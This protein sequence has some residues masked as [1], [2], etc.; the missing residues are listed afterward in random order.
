MTYLKITAP[1][2]TVTFVSENTDIVLNLT[3]YTKTEGILRAGRI[4]GVAY[5]TVTPITNIPAYDGTNTL[6]E[7]GRLSDHGQIQTIF[8]NK[9]TPF[10]S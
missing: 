1:D 7:Y 3:P 10:F 4:T 6:Y 9:D 5:S 8:S 2:K